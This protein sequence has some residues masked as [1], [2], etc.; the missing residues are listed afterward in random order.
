[1]HQTKRMAK[2]MGEAIDTSNRNLDT[3][4][5]NVNRVNKKIDK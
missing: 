1:M 3:L 4:D 5:G 2:D